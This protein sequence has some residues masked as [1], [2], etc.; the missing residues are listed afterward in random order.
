METTS[1]ASLQQMRGVPET[2]DK[3]TRSVDD[4]GAVIASVV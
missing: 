2:V 1:H 4:V 3:V